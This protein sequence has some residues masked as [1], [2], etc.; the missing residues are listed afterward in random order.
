MK[1]RLS[2]IAILCALTFATSSALAAK[3]TKKECAAA[4]EAA[5]DLRS[6]GRLRDARASLAV[7]TA[8]SCPG[9]IREDCA[10]RLKDV[11]AAIPTVVFVAKDAAGNDLG[12]VRVT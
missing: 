4:N 5:Q 1:T 3:P 12:A 10:Q 11:E 9:P 2:V 6:A 7:C 8:A